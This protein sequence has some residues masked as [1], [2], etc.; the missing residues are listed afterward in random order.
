MTLCF[1][2]APLNSETL[3]IFALPPKTLRT[4][5]MTPKA[6]KNALID[7]QRLDAKQWLPQQ[8]E[9]LHCVLHVYWKQG[10]KRR[11]PSRT[12]FPGRDS[13]DVWQ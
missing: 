1:L 13:S 12:C 11:L 10:L 5:R 4:F 2:F 9:T 8:L 3:K 6:R 7:L